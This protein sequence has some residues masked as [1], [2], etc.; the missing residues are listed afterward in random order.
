V[1]RA[2]RRGTCTT[3]TD[4]HLAFANNKE[5]TSVRA[6]TLLSTI[7]GMK[8][9]RVAA[10][11]FD[12]EGVIADV[13]PTTTLP[14]CS[15]CSCRVR[16]V[17]DGRTRFWRHL[18]LAGMR[19]RLRYRLRR[20]DC[21]RCGVRVE[22]IPWAEP[23]SWF[24]RDFEEHTAYLA[25]TTD[26]TT[27]VKMMRVAWNTVGEIARRV[28]DRLGPRDLLD[29]LKQIGIDELS[30]RRHHE[31]VTVVLDH[32][33]KRIVWAR[34]GKDAATLAE[35]FKELGTERCKQLEAVT[36]DMSAAYI[37][38]VTEASSQAKIIF[39]RF[40]VQ[41]LAHDAVDEVRRAEVRQSKGTEEA[42]VL[43]RTRFLLHKNPWNLTHLEGEKLAQLQRTNK[44]IYRAYLL[45]EGLAG[46][47]DGLD[48]DVARVKL[49][50]WIGWA[51]RSRLE[52]FKKLARTVK[53]HFEGILA[54]IPLRLNNGRTEGMN[55][56]IRTITRRSY[57]FHSASNL[58]ALIF[59][60]CSG[61][62]LLP[63][64]KLPT[65]AVAST[66]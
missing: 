6:T 2:W 60:C 56:K 23:D 62:S 24:T 10:V 59:L 7:L 31:Y 50:D 25:Q 30:Y 22:V 36:I 61:I 29:G 42:K 43:K 40:H 13:A 11:A 44:P 27:V 38:A 63:V 53:Q 49:S 54:Y 37:K 48:V 52:P 28:V 14:R 45:K 33:K 66:P 55:G 21:P 9:T 1:A 5:V 34:P 20:V 47:L 15:G 3:R 17:Y 64:L 16:K 35:F 18:D 8:H 26:K 4:V 46:I 51:A 12:E 58:I 41:R 57:G 32:V 65:K 19:L 39:D